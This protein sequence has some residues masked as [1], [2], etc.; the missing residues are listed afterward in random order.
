MQAHL[1]WQLGSE[2]VRAKCELLDR[3]IRVMFWNVLVPQC[4]HGLGIL[5][6]FSLITTVLIIFPSLERVPTVSLD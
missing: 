4:P 3:D 1:V 6:S 2:L 5:L